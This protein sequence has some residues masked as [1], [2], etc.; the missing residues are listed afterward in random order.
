MDYRQIEAEERQ[1]AKITKEFRRATAVNSM[2]TITSTSRIVRQNE[3][4]RA[5]IVGSL[6]NFQHSLADQFHSVSASFNSAMSSLNDS[7]IGLKS[8]IHSVEGAIRMMERSFVMQLQRT[9]EMN[10]Q[11]HAEVMAKVSDI[12]SSLSFVSLQL[13]THSAIVLDGI[14]MQEEM[15][16]TLI[17]SID[18]LHST[19]KSPLTTQALEFFRLGFSNYSKNLFPEAEENFIKS[20]EKDNAQPLPHYFLGKIYLYISPEGE[21]LVDYEKAVIEL[22]LTIRYLKH[23]LKTNRETAFFY[24]KVLEELALA[25]YLKGKL[26]EARL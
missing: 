6:N 10:S 20:I 3:Y 9:E 16:T 26:D 21:S 4:T 1:L 12:A 7:F 5:S 17:S 24:T 13:A 19:I 14:K 15:F 18:S 11:R 22:E 23:Y 8:G 2:A 25:Y